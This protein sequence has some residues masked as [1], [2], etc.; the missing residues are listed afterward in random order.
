MK[1][2][3]GMKAVVTGGNSGIGL[4]IAKAFVEQGAQVKII[5][6]DSIKARNVCE[7][8]LILFPSS[9]ISFVCADVS[10]KQDVDV[11]F[12]QILNE[13]KEIDILVNCA[14]ITKDNL[15][16]KMSE[17]DWNSVIQT[18]LNSVFHTSKAVIRYMLKARKGTIIN[19]S[20][21][22]GLIGNVGQS[23]YAASKAGI[24]GFSK[25]LAK[26][27]AT[28]NIRVN[29]IAPGFIE[30][31]M[32]QKLMPDQAQNILNAIPMA[33]YGQPEEIAHAAVFLASEWSKYMT[34][35]V[36]TIDGGMCM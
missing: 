7:H 29:V 20:S 13:W 2:L 10:V 33:R 26:E 36:L 28:R 17:E 16:M 14:G 3:H 34:G 1:L 11:A 24:I 5:A 9:S 31:P 8:I 30:T 6:R 15:L 18:N 35:Q 21:I 32:T 12:S 22:I 4:S 25:A 19:V 23:N 27:C